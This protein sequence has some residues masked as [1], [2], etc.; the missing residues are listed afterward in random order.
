M[1]KRNKRV[2]SI[3]TLVFVASIY[4]SVHM[5]VEVDVW[6]YAFVS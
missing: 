4:M 2:I 5:D 6:I 3:A 1:K